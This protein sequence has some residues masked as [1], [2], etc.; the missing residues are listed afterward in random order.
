MEM[1]YETFWIWNI[2]DDSDGDGFN[3]S[4]DDYPENP[5]RWVRCPDGQW[6][7]LS[8]QNSS[9]GHFSL[10]GSL[11][12]E[13][14]TIGNYQ[15]DEGQTICYESSS[16]YFVNQEASPSQQHCDA[17]FYQNDLAQSSCIASPAGN[18]TN[19]QYGDADDVTP[20][21]LQSRSATYGGQIGNYSWSN[22][23]G[24][25]FSIYVPRDTAAS[26]DL[27]NS[28]SNGD[29]NVS[30]YYYD[31]LM[32]M[33]L[34]S[35]SDN[36]TSGGQTASVTTI[37]TSFTNSSTLLVSVTPNNSSS[38]NYSFTLTLTSTIDGSIVG[39]QSEPIDAEIQVGFFQCRPGTYQGKT[40][41]GSCDSASPGR[42]VSSTG[43]TSRIHAPL[44]LISL[45]LDKHPVSKPAKVTMFLRQALLS[46]LQL[47]QETSSPNPEQPPKYNAVRGNYQ[48]S[49]AQVTCIVA[50]AG[51]YVVISGSS[52]QTACSP[53]TY[54]PSNGSTTCIDASP[55]HFVPNYTFDIPDPL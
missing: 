47:H 12:H 39:N 7:R 36:S 38:G 30:L 55:G 42:F 18:Y 54:Q 9:A 24:D 41:S 34:I 33:S 35:T 51:N 31:S 48:P 8:C 23:S 26:V 13:S 29:F 6:G 46:R 3:S 21:P 45:Y 25:L 14:C 16:G 20:T 1:E 2:S 52:N 28:N 43:A 17:G 27:T 11:F 53:G 22:D 4:V 32:A 49:F 5:A 37:G 40:G 10:Q 50:S 15:P 19:N 44:G